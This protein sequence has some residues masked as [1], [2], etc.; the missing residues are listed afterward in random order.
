MREWPHALKR[1][2]L[3]LLSGYFPGIYIDG[4]RKTTRNLSLVTDAS[5]ENWTRNLSITSH[6]RWTKLV[7]FLYV[8]RCRWQPK[9][10]CSQI[11]HSCSKVYA[12]TISL[13][14]SRAVAYL[15]NLCGFRYHVLLRSHSTARRQQFPFC[16]TSLKQMWS[17][18]LWLFLSYNVE[19]DSC[20][21]LCN[22]LGLIRGQCLHIFPRG[23]W[24]N[25]IFHYFRHGFW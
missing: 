24:R 4:Q 15:Y 1:K 21:R 17:N 18:P 8:K 9:T 19:Y 25:W 2:L 5:A 23:H 6:K 22:N 3:W 16:H 14:M 7:R 13:R 20:G 10:C 12:Y 11:H